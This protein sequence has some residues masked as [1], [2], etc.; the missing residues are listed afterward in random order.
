MLWA[1]PAELF[2]GPFCGFFP[3]G[4]RRPFFGAKT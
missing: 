2:E 3:K 4:Y 1:N